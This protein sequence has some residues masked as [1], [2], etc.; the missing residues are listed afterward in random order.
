MVVHD[1][2]NPTTQIEFLLIQAQNKLEDLE[3][4]L[5]YVEKALL[6]LV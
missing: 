1:M 4:Q 5:K 3:N 6:K 2:R